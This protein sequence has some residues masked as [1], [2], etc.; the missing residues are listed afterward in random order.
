MLNKN[1]LLP[2]QIQITVVLGIISYTLLLT[3]CS[4][5]E[6]SL[7]SIPIPE[8]SSYTIA[9]QKVLLTT[10]LPGRTAPFRIAEIRP[11]VNGLV[12]KRYFTEG[13]DVQTNQNLYQIDPAPFNVALD[14]ASASLARAEA[15][16]P[17]IQAKFQRYKDAL[18]QKAVSQQDYD[19][20]TAALKQAQAD[21]DYFRAMVEAAKINLRYTHVTSPINGRVGTSTVTEGAIVTAYQPAPLTTIQQL[22]PI[23]VDVTQSTS[24]VINLLHR[25]E[26]KQIQ[27]DGT[28]FSQVELLLEDGSKYPWKGTLQFR[29]VSVDL[30]TSSVVLRMIFPNPKGIL[31]PGM[32]VRAVVKEG[33]KDNALLVPQQAVT[34][35]VKGAPITMIIGANNK[36]E[37][38]VLQLDRAINDQWL[39]I[40]GLSGGEKVI[41]EGLQ[42]IHPGSEV[43]DVSS[44]GNVAPKAQLTNTIQTALLQH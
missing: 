5:K 7:G 38:R 32:Y 10:E 16:L 30:T 9:P 34:R 8:V 40:G 13:S 24:D 15:N 21:I 12:L 26:E 33:V 31:M 42:N 18:A 6:E 20:A 2:P 23:Y 19:D 1:P 43:K 29:D 41:M 3:G 11:Q 37:Q 14:N 28:N 27:R 17:A 25:L 39:V 35:D 22:D 36:V 4:Q 44:I